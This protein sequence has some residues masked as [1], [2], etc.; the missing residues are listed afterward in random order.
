M[1]VAI[2]G[3]GAV[4]GYFGG[5]LSR[6]GHAVTFIARGPHLAAMREHGLALETPKGRLAVDNARFIE[7]PSEAGSCD[8][9]LF[10]VKAFDIESAAAPLKPLVDGGACV[11]SVLNGVDHQERIASVL[12]AGS[13]LG[14]FS[15]ARGKQRQGGVAGRINGQGETGRAG[16]EAAA[17]KASTGR[18]R[19]AP[20]D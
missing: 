4:G 2:M 5:L 9:V 16:D 17:G 14:G 3:A 19:H 1:R 11:V 12:G 18:R 13:G 7:H 15:R 10:A 20:L 6:A 8:V